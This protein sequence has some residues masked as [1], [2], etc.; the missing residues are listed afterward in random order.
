[1]TTIYLTRKISSKLN[2]YLLEKIISII[3]EKDNSKID[4]FQ[5]F[6]VNNNQLINSQE[7]PEKSEIYN[8]AYKFKEKIKIWA[9]KSEEEAK[10]YWTIM[11]PEE[12]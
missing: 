11:F 1:M 4:Y 10:K 8:L 2:K 9:I 7:K 6:E 3:K 12:Y 5:I